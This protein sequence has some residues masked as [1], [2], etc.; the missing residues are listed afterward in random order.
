MPPLT[1][2]SADEPAGEAALHDA[3][4]RSS[5]QQPSYLVASLCFDH[6]PFLSWLI[7]ALAPTRFVE[8]GCGG[9]FS[10]F[11]ACQA[12]SRLRLP[13]ACTAVDEWLDEPDLAEAV[14]DHNEARYAAFSA[15][16]QTSFQAAAQRFAD[17]SVD[18]LHIDAGP[19]YATADE[20]FAAWRP[21]LSRAAVVLLH[22]VRGRDVAS[23]TP[24]LF[25]ALSQAHPHLAFAHGQ[26]MGVVAC[27]AVPPR[28]APLLAASTRSWSFVQDAYAVLGQAVARRWQVSELEAELRRRDVAHTAQ[29]GAVQGAVTRLAA[30]NAALHAG[31]SGARADHETDLEVADAALDRLRRRHA[32]DGHRVQAAAAHRRYAMEAELAERDTRIAAVATALAARQDALTELRSEL[33][34]MTAEAGRAQAEAARL[35]AAL[36]ALGAA[37]AALATEHRRVLGSMSWRITRPVR[38]AA[39]RHPRAARAPLAFLRLGWWIATLQFGRIAARMRAR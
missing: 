10:F 33:A 24:G 34:H 20:D 28:L 35:S 5:F 2:A 17:G 7:E 15:V 11:T 3:L 37:H 4:A 36:D 16:V 14:R 25:A 31:L 39:G 12:V 22:G 29:L 6:G 26:G 9:G 23:G 32:D 18:L 8:L 30:A 27:G 13:T 21:K 38:R 1:D 19:H